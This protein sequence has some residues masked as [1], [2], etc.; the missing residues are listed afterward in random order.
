MNLAGFEDDRLVH[1]VHFFLPNS[2][3]LI[4]DFLPRYT[5]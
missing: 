5:S 2:L 4:L 3:D 1:H